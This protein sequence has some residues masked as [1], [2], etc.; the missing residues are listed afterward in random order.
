M[1]L[2]QTIYPSQKAHT[3]KSEEYRSFF[4]QNQHWLVP[5]AAFRY[6]QE[7]YGTSDF[8]QWPAHRNYRHAEIAALAAPGSPSHDDIAFNYFLQFHLHLQLQQ[9]TEY[10][11]AN[12]VILKAAI[13]IGICIS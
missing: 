6:L 9:A 12:G 8:S 4:E 7:K 3:F 5:Y 10:A 13:P 11:R 1:S 2:L